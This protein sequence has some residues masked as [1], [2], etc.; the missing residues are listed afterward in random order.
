[1]DSQ[2]ADFIIGH[3]EAELDSL[4]VLSHAFQEFTRLRFA[5]AGLREGM[6]VLEVGSA[7]GDVAFV[8]AEFVGHSGLVVG[9]EQSPEAVERATAR[10]AAKGLSN[11]R[12]VYSGL[13]KDLPLDLEFD[14][15]VGRIVLMFLPS[16]AAALK[17]LA[18]HVRPG[19][20][21]LFQEPDMSWAKSVPKVPTVE[22]AASWMREIFMGA[23]ADSEFGPKLH[24]I[25][26][27]A[28]LPAPQ[29]R[30][31]GLIEGSDG[32]APTLLAESIRAMLPA[33]E[34]F[35]LATREEVDIDS[36]EDRIRAELQGADATMSSPLLI[37]AW[38]HLPSER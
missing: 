22:K 36:F 24:A 10:A 29:M 13:D 6:S 14:A 16:P 23:G 9:L 28:G 27:G 38:S 8:A 3:P 34:Q 5:E 33:I 31:D 12:F 32:A 20:L 15:L 7:S 19:G 18:Q 30:V 4:G 37:S 21:V 11:V 26:K 2:S 17:R 35:G 1:M 25:F